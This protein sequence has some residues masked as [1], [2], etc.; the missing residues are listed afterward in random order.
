MSEPA[1]ERALPP[2]LDEDEL[3]FE[4]IQE[5]AAAHGAELLG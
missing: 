4:R 5:V 2:P 3:D 1:G